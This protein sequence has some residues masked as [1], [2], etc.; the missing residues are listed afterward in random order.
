MLKTAKLYED[1]HDRATSNLAIV[2]TRKDSPRKQILVQ[3]MLQVGTTVESS[4]R[5][6]EEELGV[7][8]GNRA[9][10][11]GLGWLDGERSHC[12]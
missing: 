12:C 8:S 1:V 11:A 9:S 3:D 7:T 10:R 4:F 5:I 2:S 6:E